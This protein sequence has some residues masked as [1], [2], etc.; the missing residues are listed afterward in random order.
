MDQIIHYKI[1]ILPPK[2]LPLSRTIVLSLLAVPK[3]I[4]SKL[5]TDEFEGATTPFLPGFPTL[6]PPLA[7]GG[8]LLDTCESVFDAAPIFL[9]AFPGRQLRWW[10]SSLSAWKRRPQLVHSTSCC[11]DACHA[12]SFMASMSILPSSRKICALSGLTGTGLFRC[13]G[14]LSFSAFHFS[15][16]CGSWMSID[17]EPYFLPHI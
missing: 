9:A 2:L 16:H 3:R 7:V 15:K 1:N 14:I 12:A 8:L 4:V 5:L 13:F 11:L 10:T 6:L 17:L